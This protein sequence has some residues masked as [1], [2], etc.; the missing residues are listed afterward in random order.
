[1]LELNYSLNGHGWAILEIDNGEMKIEICVSYFHDSLKN[2]AESAIKVLTNNEISVVFMDE[3]G[4]HQ[5]L[6]KKIA[7]NKIEYTLIWYKDWA[8]WH[9]INEENYEVVLTGTTTLPKYIN[10][11]RK[12]LMKIYNE[13]G[14]IG[15]KEKWGKHEF[16]RSEFEKLK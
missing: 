8:S 14:E 13:F 5:L 1:M 11:V 4:E 12:I 6:L 9:L 2:L 3:P 16:P 15:Y 10:Q 7:N